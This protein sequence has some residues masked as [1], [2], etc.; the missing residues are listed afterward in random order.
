MLC[1]LG[2]YDERKA[3]LSPATTQI[4][5]LQR[6]DSFLGLDIVLDGVLN[7]SLH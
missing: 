6:F 3:L 2:L 1:K 4:I 5:Q 7:F